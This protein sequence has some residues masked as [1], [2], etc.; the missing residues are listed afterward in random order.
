MRRTLALC[1]ILG[2]VNAALYQDISHLPR[3][4]FDYI[5]VGGGT[6]GSV[7]GR[8]L[9]ENS[10][11][12]VL[13]LESGP[14]NDGVVA[15]QVPY[16]HPS[17]SGG[18]YDWNYTTTPQA[19][20]NDRVLDYPR[21]HILGGS[22]TINAMFWTRGTADDYDRW[23][24]VTG[25]SGWS[26]KRLFPYMLKIER[27][28]SPADGHNTKGQ[29][30]PSVH[31][32]SGNLK[33]SLPGWPLEIGKRVEDTARELGGDFK[34][35]LDMNSGKPL[36]TSW[37]QCTIGDGERSSAATAYLGRS[38][39]NRP[40]LHV[41][42]NTR[43]TRV[44]PSSARG[45]NYVLSFRTVEIATSLEP[46][47]TRVELTARK[48]VILSAGAVGTPHILLHSGIGDRTALNAQ[49]IRPLVHLPSVGQNLTDHPLTMIVWN[50]NSTTTGDA[51]RDPTKQA[52]A[53]EQWNST[54]RGPLTS[55]GINQVAW[56]RLPNDS[57]IW[58]THE[59]PAAG[60]NTPHIEL[61]IDNS[62]G[63]TGLT[64]FFVGMGL[65]VPTPLSRGSL[66]LRTS[67]P[68]DQPNIDPNLFS[69]PF[70]AFAMLQ[71]VRK[72]RE[73]FNHSTWDGYV[74]NLAGPYTNEIIDDDEKTIAILRDT[75]SHAWHP[76][77]TAAMSR[78]NVGWGVVDP[79]LRVKGVTGLRIV[80]ASVMPFI[81]AAHTQAPVYIIAER[82]ADLIKEST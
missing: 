71:A 52:Q 82:A 40:N 37:L 59:D 28:V 19:G 80:D 76:V 77:G 56:L 45:N 73:F 53:F 10:R 72:A 41:V 29:V 51:L 1:A 30:D 12:Q 7:L 6:A 55:I 74:L 17:L 81:P 34:P 70:D 32:T 69:S 78:R 39:L 18:T 57:P 42:V 5:I 79:D 13:L 22:T 43:V 60:K 66:T 2:T 11:H 35:I 46:N 64:G 8:R 65:A 31:G 23:A 21:G 14:S 61:A 33:I 54:R 27:L 68:F 49:G 50:A 75:A 36:G 44:L 48:E 3:V 38:V 26:W 67:N 25:D 47:G 62:A 16:F 58:E 9:S 20:F 4:Q 15:S 24:E 63:F